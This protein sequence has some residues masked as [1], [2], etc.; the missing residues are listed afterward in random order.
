M[1]TI[2]VKVRKKYRMPKGRL[3]SK[4][5]R[6]IRRA[7]TPTP[8]LLTNPKL[9]MTMCD[10]PH[11]D[12][13]LMRGSVIR[14]Q[15]YTEYSMAAANKREQQVIAIPLDDCPFE[16]IQKEIGEFEDVLRLGFFFSFREIS[17]LLQQQ[18]FERPTFIPIVTH[19]KFRDL[20]LAVVKINDNQTHR[21]IRLCF[22]DEVSDVTSSGGEL[23]ARPLDHLMR[24]NW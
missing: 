5:E 22:S 11:P 18:R 3:E 19:R 4:R 12:S 16:F 17:S 21:R 20:K 13:L 1:D 9:L 15:M 23:I 2:T 10:F 8:L 7:E 24:K 6:S 14:K